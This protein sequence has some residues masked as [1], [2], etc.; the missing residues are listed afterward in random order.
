MRPPRILTAALIAALLIPG[1]SGCSQARQYAEEARSSYISARAVLVGLQEFP[2]QVE[3][4]LRAKDLAEAGDE[5]SALV[6]DARQ[7][8]TA[9]TTAFNDCRERCERL[10]E[11]G[12]DE[13]NVYADML[14]ELVSLNEQ[15]INTYSEFIGI[16]S[17]T[18]DGLPYNQ[19]PDLLM[20]TLEYMDD[21]AERIE[22]L[23]EGIRPLEEEAESLYLSLTG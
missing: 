6:E 2:S 10:K 19:E 7:L 17:S 8:A 5:V 4:A 22:E 11:E 12:D 21:T 9:S 20:P 3:E 1:L 16:T 18:V 14:L 13:F 15:V 23:M